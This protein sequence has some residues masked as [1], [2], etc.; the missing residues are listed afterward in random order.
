MKKLLLPVLIF[1]LLV[2]ACSQKTEKTEPIAAGTA[3]S[4]NPFLSEYTT[5]FQVP[6]FDLIKEEH[7]PP[8]IQEGIKQQ[9]KEI[10]AIVKN[11][12]PPTFQNTVE[13]LER[14]GDLLDKV[15][16]VLSNLL[17]ANTT[18]TLQKIATDAAPL[19]S[20]HGDDIILNPDLFKRVKAV[21]DEKGTLGL[22][23]EQTR[24]IEKIYKNF[25]RNGA[26][27]DAENQARLR[28][29]NEEL[30]V[31]TLKFGD[32]VLRDDNAFQL[33]IEKRED[34]A[35][36]PPTVIEGAAEA[37]K[38]KG[39]EGKWI[40]TPHKPSLI[41]FLQFSAKRDLREKMFKAY[42]NRGNNN[43]ESD[44]K[45]NASKI[46]SLRVERVG[47][48][49]YKTHADYVLEEYMA[50]TPAGV[51][52]LLNRLWTPALARAKAEAKDL[53]ALIDKEG[54][55]FKLEAW[56]WWYYAEKLRKS[57]YD[58]DENELRPY[59]KLE[60][61]RD[62]AFAV[63]NK[64]WGITFTL[65]T[66]LP[67][68][69]PDARTFEVKEADGSH[70]GILYLDY[71]PRPSKQGGAWSDA[72]RT[73]VKIG[74]KFIHPVVVNCGNFSKPTGDEPALL[75][76]EEVQALYHEF[77]HAL[78]GLLSNI[79]YDTLGDVPQDFVELPSQIMEQ[80]AGE[81][82]VL[83]DYARNYKTGEPIPDGLIKKIETSGLFN[84]GFA[85]VEY[86]AACYLDMDWHT[87]TGTAEKEALSYEKESLDKIGLIPEIVVRYRTPYF[88]HIFSGGY[89]SGYYSYI[90]SEVL[91]SDAFE[92]FK[93]KG[94]FDRATAQSYRKNIL[95]PGGTEEAM[96]LYKR[97][98]G[99]EPKIEPLLKRRGLDNK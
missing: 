12:E 30:S 19:L 26:N 46:A 37:A 33:V 41:P 85:T 63:A 61:V 36:L 74:D 97:F 38:A 68:Y 95:E 34:L 56:D 99:A 69:H 84:Q 87:L 93:E 53:Q 47:L 96:V 25:V 83:K 75:S 44:N 21:Y 14:S 91:D 1:S 23:P 49:G 65:R 2:V 20:R 3:V 92:A 88:S 39:F 62:G 73:Q 7:F 80:W 51:Y 6:P 8:A 90:W 24:L 82:S 31:L 9:Q 72:F 94:I 50:K 98:R 28:K 32:N 5:P 81:P 11:G 57:K 17:S 27:L 42:I 60:N 70:I 40:F 10:E 86:L 4:S 54:G 55:P 89:S 52:G 15:N 71:F 59:F 29:I 35:G 58:L 76:Y 67:K 43:N 79:T 16:H 48:L 64:L 13:A 45:A 66:D 78:H 77:G 22:A 18:D